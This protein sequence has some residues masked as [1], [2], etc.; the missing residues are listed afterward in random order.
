MSG[1]MTRLPAP[2][3]K[4]E[5]RPDSGCGPLNRPALRAGRPAPRAGGP[6]APATA[7][8]F[9]DIS[10]LSPSEPRIQA[11]LDVAAPGDRHEREADRAA[12]QVTGTPRPARPAAPRDPGASGGREGLVR[13]AQAGGRPLTPG[14]R[15]DFEP[16]FGHDFGR[17]RVH[18]DGAADAAARAVG[19]RAF[20][21]GP[22][23]VFRRGAYEPGSSSGRWLMAHE[24]AHVVQQTGRLHRDFAVEPLMPLSAGPHL[25]EMQITDAIDFNA[26]RYFDAAQIELLRDVLGISKTPAII[27]RDFVLAVA[28][29]QEQFGDPINGRLSR[30]T[31]ATLTTELTAEG[32]T[33]GAT[34]LAI[35]DRATETR[36]NLAT[37]TRTDVFDAELDH[38]NA[39]LTLVMRVQFNFLPGGGGAWP[40]PGDQVTWRSRFIS[41]VENRWN[42]QLLMQRRAA[43]DRYLRYYSTAVRVV[44]SNAN[45]HYTANVTYETGHTTSGI[46]VSTNTGTFD[47]LDVNTISYPFPPHT[48]QRTTVEH[49]FGHMLGL[50]HI[51]CSTNDTACYG[52][53]DAERR[54]IMGYGDEVSTANATPFLDAM[55]TITGLAWDAVPMRRLV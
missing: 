38:A 24:L 31:A 54:N 13:A 17:V 32:V 23:V 29:Y 28:R 55:R 37:G 25:T 44:A 22:H 16:R 35:R 41:L 11:W 50:D 42:H 53:T 14:E 10:I 2:S 39:L 15:G 6:A 3:R 51:A 26:E 49:E 30:M 40:S 47:S 9:A 12:E 33:D 52:T 19:A 48:Y 27:D 36:N 21:L 5:C 8:R 43:S 34:E 7:H 1:C 45:P 4:G 18:E 20:A 46:G